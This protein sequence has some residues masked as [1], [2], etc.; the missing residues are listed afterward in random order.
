M[1]RFDGVLGL[2]YPSLAEILGNPVFDNMLA[3]KIVEKPVFSF[4]LCRCDL[5]GFKEFHFRDFFK[6]GL[7]GLSGGSLLILRV[8]V[9]LL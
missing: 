2:G 8:K 6:L 3:Q 4:Y 9:S 7:T 5:T 1:A